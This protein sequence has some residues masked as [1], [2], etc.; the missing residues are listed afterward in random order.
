MSETKQ[1]HQDWVTGLPEEGRLSRA[2]DMTIELIPILERCLTV[3]CDKWENGKSISSFDTGHA[4]IEHGAKTNS[5]LARPP[6]GNHPATQ[7]ASPA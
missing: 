1:Q 7:Q 3:T 4:S 2:S 6:G 5:H